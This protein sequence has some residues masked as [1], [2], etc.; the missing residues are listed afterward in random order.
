MTTPIK[1]FEDDLSRAAKTNPIR[2]T[3]HPHALPK[4]SVRVA[5][6]YHD[7]SIES[8]TTQEKEYDTDHY[9]AIETHPIGVTTRP[10]AP[11]KGFARAAL[12]HHNRSIESMNVPIEKI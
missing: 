1:T 4:G 7:C 10:H 2:V 5:P 6:H 8:V 12:R 11:P 9:K 3:M